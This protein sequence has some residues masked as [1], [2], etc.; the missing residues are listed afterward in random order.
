VVTGSGCWWVG[1]LGVPAQA[2][3][4]PIAFVIANLEMDMNEVIWNGNTVI[5]GVQCDGYSNTWDYTANAGSP[6][7]YEDMWV[8]SKAYCNPREWSTNT[9]HHVQ[10]T[11]SRNSAGHVT[12]KSI[13]L[14]GVEQVI[15]ETVPSAF[16]LGWGKCLLT[17]F[18]VDGL[19]GYGSAT[20]YLDHLTVYRW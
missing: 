18:Q 4:E 6:K 3:G 8:H 20:V 12:Y 2:S 10:M 15:N 14:D 16:S 7:K 5:Y 19:G 11:Y 1:A 13:W 17:N 9:W